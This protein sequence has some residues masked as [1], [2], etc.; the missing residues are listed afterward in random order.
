MK[1]SSL[2]KNLSYDVYGAAPEA[3]VK[4]IVYDSRKAKKGTVFVCLIGAETD[5]HRYARAA[6]EQGCRMF[7]VQKGSEETAD[8]PIG[9][10]GYKDLT[11]ITVE[12][13]RHALA[14]M[15]DIFFSHPSGDV[16]VI[17]ITGTKGKTTTTYILQTMLNGIGVKTGI[18]GTNGASYGTTHL[19]TVNTTPESYEIQKILREMADNG[20]EAVAMEVSSIGVQWHRVDG[21]EFFC[22]MFTNISPDHIGGNEHKTFEEYYGWKK[23][24]FSMCPQAVACFDDP[25][26][27]DMLEKVPGRKLFYGHGEGADFR[28]LHTLPTK[29]G[30]FLGVQFDLLVHGE[31][32]GTFEISQPGE[33]SVLNALGALA[34]AECMGYAP[35]KFKKALTKVSVPGRAQAVSMSEDYGILID[36]A[37]NGISF[38]SIVETMRAYH[39]KRILTLFGSVG[40]RAQL[41]RQELGTLAGQL[42]DYTIITEDDPGYEQPEKIAA[43]IASFVEQNGGHGKYA[44]IPNRN[45]AL[46]YAVNMMQK[47][48]FLLCLGKGHE[49]FMKRN[50]EKL[51]FDEQATLL[52]ALKE[53]ENR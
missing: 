40:D 53:K 9:Q 15:S 17:G 36:F 10:K 42:S 23:A 31:A 20:V 1:L 48:D 2:L 11:M 28:A 3:E 16:K 26:S 43:E 12:K 39:P 45:D 13:S 7:V 4:D 35:K 47:G 37:H 6:L 52:A 44:V 27:A 8:L 19:Q 51:P 5:G 50:G 41:R 38:E 46:R 25:A 21:V 24:F 22:G 18:I 34:V 14:L 33:F 29:H 32:D 30:S 49:K